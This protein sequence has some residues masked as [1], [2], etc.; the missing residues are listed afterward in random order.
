[1]AT[2]DPSYPL[3]SP[4][5]GNMRA[6]AV[7]SLAVSCWLA[8]ARRKRGSRKLCSKGLLILP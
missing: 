5:L 1:V 6:N 8:D 7:Q 4:N 2:S 3:S